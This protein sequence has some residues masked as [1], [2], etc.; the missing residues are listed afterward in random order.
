MSFGVLGEYVKSLFASTPCK[1]RFF[2][3]IL[4][5]RLDTFR[6]FSMYAE[7]MKNMQKEIFSFNNARGL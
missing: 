6:V 5:I 1:H 2:P 7:R 4:R 3:R